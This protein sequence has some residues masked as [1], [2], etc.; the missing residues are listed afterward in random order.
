MKNYSV[1]SQRA[2]IIRNAMTLLTLATVALYVIFIQWVWGWATVLALWKSAGLGSAFL[3]L[4]ALLGTYVLRTWRIYDYF[5]TETGGR[6]G[7]LLR[8]TQVHNLLNIMLPFRS[9]EAS[10]P[11]LM[12][13][14][15]DL[16][17]ARSTAALFVMRLFDLHA[18]L[19]AA[20]IG[21]VLQHHSSWAWALWFGFRIRFAA[22]VLPAKAERLLAEVE[23]GLPVDAAAFARAWGA[24]LINWFT[25]IAVLAW[26]LGLLGGV[27]MAPGFGGALG[28]E[29]SSVLP[30]HAPAGVGTYPAG[31]S[32]GAVAF[33][34]AASG[35]AFEDL[36]QA[37][38]NTHLLVIV[39][40]LI[41]TALS[42]F[43]A[44]GKG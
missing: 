36:A 29:L 18:L 22:R 20:G 21:L 24:T 9:G 43:A 35:A 15:F 32:A 42:L 4:A 34:A 2:W 30:V 8:L 11:L 3:A 31:I 23:A 10:F 12:K 14:E 17:L 16:S 7:T 1:A 33:G 6:F 27:S 38:V 26:V 25:K 13:R 37:A 44:R 19:A 41:G 39:S 40:S 5:P 28:G